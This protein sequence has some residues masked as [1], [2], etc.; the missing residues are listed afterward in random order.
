MLTAEQVNSE[1]RKQAGR[2]RAA[3]DITAGITT[4]AKEFGQTSATVYPY[5]YWWIVGYNEAVAEAGV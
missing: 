5:T 4:E 1:E 3:A 2:A